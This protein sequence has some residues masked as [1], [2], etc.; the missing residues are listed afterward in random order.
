MCNLPPPPKLRSVIGC[1][2]WVR[3]LTWSFV[4]C[5]NCRVCPESKICRLSL[6]SAAVY[7]PPLLTL[8]ACD[9]CNILF[10][11]N[12]C[13]CRVI[14]P[15]DDLKSCLRKGFSVE[16]NHFRWLCFHFLLTRSWHK[17]WAAKQNCLT[18][19][20]LRLKNWNIWQHCVSLS[21]DT[22]YLLGD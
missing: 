6:S 10:S 13:A 5:L 11:V 8:F 4:W 22:R 7:R 21:Q 12:Y 1:S 17:E 19:S 20:L 2:F 16:S 14:D 18:L 15:M 9:H 3:S